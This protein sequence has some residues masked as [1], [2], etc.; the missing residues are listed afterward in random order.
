M[1][2]LQERIVEQGNQHQ[3]YR[4]DTEKQIEELQVEN[5]RLMDMIVKYS[6]NETG[7]VAQCD[8]ITQTGSVPLGNRD[9]DGAQENG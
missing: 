8:R 2:Q 4:T 5:T 7:K 6:I 3:V 9:R 1:K